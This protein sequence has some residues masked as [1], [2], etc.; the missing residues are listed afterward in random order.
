MSEPV[1]VINGEGIAHE[2][3]EGEAILINFKTG[4]YY[5]LDGTGGVIWE[6][7]TAGGASAATLAAVLAPAMSADPATVEAALRVFLEELQR[8]D[9]VSLTS[10]PAVPL[11]TLAGTAPLKFEPPVLR[12][13]TDLEA[14][15]LLDPIH[16]VAIGGWPSTRPDP[17]TN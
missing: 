6:Q 2:V 11:A 12:K 15:L 14:L 16:D 10:Q 3:L 7:L 1:Y 8:E 13:Y 17:K 9:L 4:S 5:S